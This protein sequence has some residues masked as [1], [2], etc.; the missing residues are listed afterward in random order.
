MRPRPLILILLIILLLITIFTLTTHLLTFI[1]IFF[2]HAGVS[3]TQEEIM[4]MYVNGGSGKDGEILGRK[5]VIPRIIHWVF[6]DWGDED[7]I[8]DGDGLN[9]GSGLNGN[10]NGSV[11]LPED[12]EEARRVY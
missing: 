7:G 12:W 1:R 5:E 3:V 4:D 6:H 8:G 9:D 10:G 2:S 11:R